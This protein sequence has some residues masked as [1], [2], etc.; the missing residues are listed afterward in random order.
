MDIY[1]GC[2]GKIIEKQNNSDTHSNHKKLICWWRASVGLAGVQGQGGYG[3]F[4]GV[5]LAEIPT[6][7]GL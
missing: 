7:G 6:S 1:T 3:E 4:I 5:T 2:T